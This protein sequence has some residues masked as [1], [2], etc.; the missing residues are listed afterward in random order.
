MSLF[1]V[2]G[3]AGTGVNAEQTWLDTI[4][5]NVANMNDT[6]AVNQPIYQQ[7]VVEVQPA[8]GPAL[9]TSPNATAYALGDGVSVVGIATPTPNGVLSHDP[10]NPLANAQGMVKMTGISLSAQLGS[11]VNAQ[12]SYQANVSVI[13]H[14]KSAY[15][16]VLG[17]T[18]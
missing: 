13:N 7:Q 11:L 18:A 3:V 6:S 4:A 14:A 12:Y 5:S 1:G 17:I 9:A 15:E 16:A 8:A 2:I 10:T